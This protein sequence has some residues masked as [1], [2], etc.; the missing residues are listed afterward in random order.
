MVKEISD[1]ITERS[2]SFRS[3]Q[4]QRNAWWR[5]HSVLPIS[6]RQRRRS[7]SGGFLSF[8]GE[9]ETKLLQVDTTFFLLTKVGLGQLH[10]QGGRGVEQ[11]FAVCFFLLDEFL[12]LKADVDMFIVFI[13]RVESSSIFPTSCKC[14][15]SKCVCLLR[16]GNS[17]QFDFIVSF[18]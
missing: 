10:Y 16:K 8:K 12:E 1:V 17:Y 9:K 2:F 13:L 14:W 18:K 7:S 3:E 5:S 6:C 15:Q 11:D 4:Q